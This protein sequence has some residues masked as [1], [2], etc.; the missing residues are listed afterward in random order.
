MVQIRVCVRILGPAC[1]QG[2]F[3][4]KLGPDLWALICLGLLNWD[5]GPKAIV[6]TMPPFF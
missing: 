5:A 2:Y 6:P 1:R 3:G 4:L